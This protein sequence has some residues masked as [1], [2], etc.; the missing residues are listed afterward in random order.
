MPDMYVCY[1]QQV[2]N[3]CYHLQLTVIFHK[4]TNSIASDQVIA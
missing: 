2:T 3:C 1:K 4:D